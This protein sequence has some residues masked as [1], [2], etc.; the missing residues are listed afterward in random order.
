[1][2]FK[3]ITKILFNSMNLNLNNLSSIHNTLKINV[4]LTKNIFIF[5][6]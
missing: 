1:M 6:I 4:N 5:I 2:N 3:K